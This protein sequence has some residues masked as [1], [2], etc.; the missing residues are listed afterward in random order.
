MKA[1][2][3]KTNKKWG[4]RL[5]IHIYI[6]LHMYVKYFLGSCSAVSP[7]SVVFALFFR[8]GRVMVE[9]S[10]EQVPP[11]LQHIMRDHLHHL[12]VIKDPSLWPL[13]GSL[14]RSS[15]MSPEHLCVFIKRLLNLLFSASVSALG[16]RSIR[17]ITTIITFSTFWYVT[18]L[19]QTGLLIFF[20]FFF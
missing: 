13:V 9:G 16:F 7:P 18:A 10:F 1:Y 20:N 12:P 6:D 14:S 2:K 4:G 17:R 5:T 8:I 19:F 3:Q 15:R 11:H